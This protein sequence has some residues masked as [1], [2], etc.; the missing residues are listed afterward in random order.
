MPYEI[1]FFNDDFYQTCI[2]KFSNYLKSFIYSDRHSP[3]FKGLLINNYFDDIIHRLI[4]IL[5]LTFILGAFHPGIY[6]Y[7]Q[8][9]IIYSWM[10]SIL[11]IL[12]ITHFRF[13][14]GLF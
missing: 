7:V 8:R 12:F 9:C 3:Y 5:N 14:L 4:D 11:H 6:L 2:F 13:H 1:F 10:N